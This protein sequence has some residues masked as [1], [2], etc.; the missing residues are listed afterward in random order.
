[1]NN[2]CVC[3]NAGGSGVV[4]TYKPELMDIIFPGPEIPILR[5]PP[6]PME[7]I[8]KEG[9]GNLGDLNKFK[10]WL[11]DIIRSWQTDRKPISGAMAR[12]V[13]RWYWIRYQLDVCDVEYE[14]IT[15]IDDE[16]IKDEMLCKRVLDLIPMSGSFSVFS[17]KTF[18]QARTYINVCVADTLKSIKSKNEALR[19]YVLKYRIYRGL[20]D[21]LAE[22]F[23][24][25]CP[26]F[27]TTMEEVKRAFYKA[28]WYM[29]DLNRY[30]YWLRAK[31]FKILMPEGWPE[32]NNRVRPDYNR[33][34]QL[35]RQATLGDT[36]YNGLCLK[37]KEPQTFIMLLSF[38]CEQYCA[39]LE[40]Y[41]ELIAKPEITLEDLIEAEKRFIRIPQ[42]VQPS[43]RSRKRRRLR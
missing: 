20:F 32:I 30:N 34:K 27:P 24:Q 38:S 40:V 16:R 37:I 7:E 42:V 8:I 4:F 31:A 6:L 2:A 5:P 23:E 35:W 3:A 14:F 28:G 39:V 33:F 29:N 25:E 41:D 11:A 19:A 22:S 15:A 10:I 26:L 1:M 18:L 21:C 13:Y 12:E 43:R 17:E 36:Q 9:P